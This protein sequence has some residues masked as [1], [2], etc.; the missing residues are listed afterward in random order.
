[1]SAESTSEKKIRRLSWSEWFS[2]I[3]ETFIAYSREATL[4]HSASLAYYTLFALIPIVYLAI[5]VFGRVVGN[6]VVRETIADFLQEHVG[7][8]DISGI[9]DFLQTVD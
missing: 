3:K 7:I 8:T 5:N 4:M 9:L 2:L 1:M 6:E